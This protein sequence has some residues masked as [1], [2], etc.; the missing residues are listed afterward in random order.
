MKSCRKTPSPWNP[1]EKPL[2][3][4]ILQKKPLH[5]EILQK[6]TPSPWNPTEKP[7]R[8]E[9]L[10]KKTPSP[11]N[12]TEK[13]LRHE[14]L[15]KK[16][17]SPWNPT[18]KTPFTLKSY[19]KKPPSPWNPTEKPLHHEILQKKTP[20]PWNPTEKNPFTMKS[21]RKTPF[22]MKHDENMKNKLKTYNYRKKFVLQ[23]GKPVPAW[24]TTCSAHASRWETSTDQPAEPQI[25]DLC[26]AP[27]KSIKLTWHIPEFPHFPP[28][29][30]V[31]PWIPFH[32]TFFPGSCHCLCCARF[33]VAA[34]AK[35]FAAFGPLS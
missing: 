33:L 7:L 9:I 13:P 22:T 1:A 10:Q 5:H 30:L 20:S 17:P 18:E 24:P 8:H 19:R 16:T 26:Y 21:Y 3:H 34:P 11:W 29:S 31:L 35:Y 28:V 6:K 4:E 27:E 15:Q 14:I 12:P 23:F 25:N 2:H 32:W